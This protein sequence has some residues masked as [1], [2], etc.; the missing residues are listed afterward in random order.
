[1]TLPPEPYCWVGEPHYPEENIVNP[2]TDVLPAQARK[3]LY[4]IL[5]VA[6]L[7]F[8]AYQASEGDW[9]VFAGGLVTALLGATAASNTPT[10]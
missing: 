7:A 4:A 1:M 8:A 3:V 10:G 2:L 5:F 9:L 6:A